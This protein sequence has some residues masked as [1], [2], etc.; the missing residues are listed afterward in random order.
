MNTIFSL[1]ISWGD[2]LNNWKKKKK[3]KKNDDWIRRFNN[4][5]VKMQ[6]I[7]KKKIK[8]VVINKTNC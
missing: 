1:F 7:Y 8:F 4:R 3:E 5:F 6:T 2:D